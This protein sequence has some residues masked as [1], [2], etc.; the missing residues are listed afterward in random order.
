M[1]PRPVEVPG[2]L[3]LIHLHRLAADSREVLPAHIRID[4]GGVSVTVENSDAVVMVRI[5]HAIDDPE[6][7]I[8]AVNVHY[9]SFAALQALDHSRRL[10]KDVAIQL[11]SEDL[12][13]LVG[14]REVTTVPLLDVDPVD[15]RRHL[16][17]L[18]IRD[19]IPAIGDYPVSIVEALRR[20]AGV[21]HLD[22]QVPVPDGAEQLDDDDLVEAVRRQPAILWTDRVL[23][24]I[25]PV[26]DL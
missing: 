6:E 14:G 15:H 2:L 16:A 19:R 25:Q 8:A 7:T 22:L 26:R 3:R 12:R 20:I 9:L 10:R 23:A 13:L 21:E 1:K 17:E 5:G 11:T 18:L 24:V 4:D